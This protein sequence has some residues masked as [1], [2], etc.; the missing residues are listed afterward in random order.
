MAGETI[1]P[2]SYDPIRDDL[3]TT[4]TIT[5]GGPLVIPAGGYLVLGNDGN[6]AGNGGVATDY[7]Y[8][9]EFF[10][11]SLKSD[12]AFIDPDVRDAAPW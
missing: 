11:S 12:V 2:D 5:N 3:F 8:G 4:H 7:V 1:T 6:A 10:L 9:S